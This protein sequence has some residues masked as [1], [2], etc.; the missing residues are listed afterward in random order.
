MKKTR[1]IKIFLVVTVSLT[2]VLGATNVFAADNTTSFID[3]TDT[4]SSANSSNTNSSNTSSNN[5]TT[6]TNSSNTNL[7]SNT[8]TNANTNTNITNTTNRTTNTSSYNNTNLP[9]TGLAES[10][11]M[12]CVI[13][14]LAVS[15]IYAFKKLRDYN[16]L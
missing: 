11:S 15:A 10:G 8:N 4:N 1:L 6:N 9:S 12:F 3:V 13:F 16:K 14:A 5:T 7:T 2:L